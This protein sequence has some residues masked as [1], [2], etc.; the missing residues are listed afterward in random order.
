MIKLKLLTLQ[1]AHLKAKLTITEHKMT[2]LMI[3]GVPSSARE[4]QKIL[5]KVLE[6]T[7]P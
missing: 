5:K 6:E 7:S 1:Y 3:G 4:K 2:H